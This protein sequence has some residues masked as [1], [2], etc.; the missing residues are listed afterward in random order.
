MEQVRHENGFEWSGRAPLEEAAFK[1]GFEDGEALAR[2]REEVGGG[3]TL[4][5]GR[6]V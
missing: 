2:I 1:G 4:L 6:K 3:R 5:G